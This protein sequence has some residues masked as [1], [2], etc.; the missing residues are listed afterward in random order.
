MSGVVAADLLRAEFD[1]LDSSFYAL[2]AI[3]GKIKVLIGDVYVKSSLILD[4]NIDTY[5][6]GNVVSSI[7][8]GLVDIVALFRVYGVGGGEKTPYEISQDDEVVGKLYLLLEKYSF[9][10]KYLNDSNVDKSG[11]V[12]SGFEVV[13]RTRNIIKLIRLSH[14]KALND[15]TVAELRAQKKVYS[16]GILLDSRNISAHLSAVLSD[17]LDHQRINHLILLLSVIGG[18]IITIVFFIIAART[19]VSS[20][21]LRFAQDIMDSI[22]GPIFV[23]D[24]QRLIRG[25][26]KSFWALM[27]GAPEQFIGKESLSMI[28]VDQVAN[29]IEQDKAVIRSGVAVTNEEYVTKADGTT[30]ISSTAK[31]PLIMAD[32][33]HGMVGV[34]RDITALKKTE[35]ELTQYRE[36]LEQ[37]VEIQTKDIVAK[38]E[39]AEAANRAKSE[40]LSN[41]SHEL[42]T[43]MH[44]I[45]SYSGMGL[46]MVK[47][48]KSDPTKLEKYFNN[49]VA[50]AKRLLLLIND[51]L[52]LSK[53]ESGKMQF[54]FQKG[55]LIEV[56]G[57][58]VVELNQ[59]L[60]NKN[61]TFGI[62]N[63]ASETI[64]MFDAR[65]FAE[66]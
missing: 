40:F 8:P 38:K 41:M 36:N 25:G 60:E 1:S 47:S 39:L 42:R 32:G 62:N 7:E 34:V 29:F 11:F 21:Q 37:L 5:F 49:S 28:P 27:G 4:P 9:S 54:T 45:L 52:D 61:L 18:F 24:G 35:E 57:H 10:L 3:V 51:L 58:C 16:D 12:E 44:P 2:G 15:A 43:P 48:G 65:L 23:K 6:L 55:D 53:I 50:A 46:E 31:S 13:E 64:V 22:S 17:R 66:R 30:I 26:N 56:I 20:Q 14:D 59:L 33:S 19:I 63:N